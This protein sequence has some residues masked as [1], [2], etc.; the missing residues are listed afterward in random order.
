M[1]KK[2][3]QMQKKILSSNCAFIPAIEKHCANCMS[4]R[5]VKQ[6][7][8]LLKQLKSVTKIPLTNDFAII[9]MA[10]KFS[11]SQKRQVTIRRIL[12]YSAAAVSGIAAIYTIMLHG[13]SP[14]DSDDIFRKSWNWDNFEE[15]IFIL[16]TAAAVSHQDITIGSSKNAALN[17]FIEKEIDIEQI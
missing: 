10:Q 1:K 14:A 3:S 4:C 17:E 11:K 6:N 8:E 9:R 16:D 13:L 15:K 12:G 5:Q 2:C 7:W